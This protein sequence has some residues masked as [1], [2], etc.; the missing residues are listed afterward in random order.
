MTS[1]EKMEKKPKKAKK[2]RSHKYEEK[3]RINGSFQDLMDALVPPAEKKE[4][5]K[6]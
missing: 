2:E 5:K 4:K 1:L 6:G 3:V